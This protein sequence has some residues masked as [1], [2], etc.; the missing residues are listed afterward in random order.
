MVTQ[1]RPAV[2]ASCAH[3][4]TIGGLVIPA[5]NVRL[6][7][8]GVDF[9]ARHQTVLERSWLKTRCQVCDRPAGRP[10]V[11][12]GGPDELAAGQFDESPVC[13]ACAAYTSRA[14]PMIAGRQDRS[15]ARPRL[16]EGRRGGACPDPACGCDGWVPLD[17]DQAEEREARAWYAVFIDPAGYAV[18]VEETG[19][20]RAGRR[21]RRIA[22]HGGRLTA[23]PLKVVQV[24]EPG[25]GRVWRRLPPADAAALLPTDYRLP[26]EARLA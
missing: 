18:T 1:D 19:T 26:P 9:R 25:I 14:C 3:R 5:V 8:G 13:T 21:H 22:V 15:P 4:P 12:F 10:V 24:S 20:V 2:P 7:G 6:A 11:L 23:P 17:T 16:S